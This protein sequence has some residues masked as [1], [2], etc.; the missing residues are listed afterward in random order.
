MKNGEILNSERDLISIY[1]VSRTVV[2]EAI[3]IL[4]SNELNY[5]AHKKI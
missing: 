4:A 2:L 3:L 5:L 1:Y